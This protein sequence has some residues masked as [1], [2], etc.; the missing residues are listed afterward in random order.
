MRAGYEEAG[1]AQ[2]SGETL[3]KPDVDVIAGSAGV[4]AAHAQCE[5]AHADKNESGWKNESGVACIKQAADKEGEN[6]HDEGF[7]RADEVEH[8]EVVRW[9]ERLL[10]ECGKGAKGIYQAP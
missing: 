6:E 1:H 5:H 2:A 7:C 10:V 4:A 3:R 8:V 9:Y